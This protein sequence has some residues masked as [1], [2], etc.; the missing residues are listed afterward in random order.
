MPS[1][2]DI[3]RHSPSILYLYSFQHCL[4]IEKRVN[5]YKNLLKIT[6]ELEDGDADSED[7]GENQITLTTIEK[8]LEKKL[9]AFDKSVQEYEAILQQE[10]DARAKIL[11]VSMAA[12]LRF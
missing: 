12:V 4:G 1:K 5:K 3:K 9:I 11:N 7:S 2:L 8:R 10:K 6:T